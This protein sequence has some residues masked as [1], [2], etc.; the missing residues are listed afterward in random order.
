M[1][2]QIASVADGRERWALICADNREV[3]PLLADKSVDHVITDPPYEAEAHT[4]GRRIKIAGGSGHYG[5]VGDLALN[6]EPITE[7]VRTHASAHIARLARRWMLVFC[8]VE[9]VAAWRRELVAVGASYR[10][11]CAWLKLDAQPQLSGDRPGMGYESIVCAH[12]PGRSRW[13]GGGKRGV[14]ESARASTVEHRPAEHMTEK[15]TPLMLQ[16]VEDFTDPGD[17]VLDPFAGSGTT[18]VACL[19]LGRR[20]IG[21]EKDAAFAKVATERLEAGSQGLTLRAARAGQLPLFQ[22][23]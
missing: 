21:I 5:V 1:A 12:A 8:Q 11:T 3:L 18:G 13:N 7:E 9:A 15:P 19:R 2:E 14:Y 17:L 23:G 10:R 20:F 16:L 4:K 6:F 22:T